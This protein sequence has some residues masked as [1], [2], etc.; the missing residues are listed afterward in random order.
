MG[1]TLSPSE[2]L[3]DPSWVADHLTDPSICIADC[4]YRDDEQEAHVAYLSGH[5]PG[6]VHVFW[7]RDLATGAAPVTNLLPA[8]EQAAARLLALGIGND[9]TVVA[10][11]DD[12]GHH[13]ARLWLV[14]AYFGHDQ[15]KLLNGGVQRWQAEGRPLA[16]DEVI[17]APAQFTPGA[18]HEELRIRADELARRLDDPGLAVADVRTGG[19]YDGT[20]VRAA[21]GGRI[22]GARHL[23]WK[24]NLRE[25]C[26]FRSMNEIAHRHVLAGITPDREVVVYCQ[27]GVRAS[28]AALSLLMAG[29]PRVRVYDGSWNEWGNDPSR[30]VQ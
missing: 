18:P 14:L 7:P 16:T 22:P 24:D 28:H 3:G 12:G 5:L 21:R 30:P 15:F 13:A 11:D 1:L 8:K 4:R 19:E 23:F 17:P 20:L 9:M 2:I 6:A 25:D 10:Y 27:L 29:Y 26:T